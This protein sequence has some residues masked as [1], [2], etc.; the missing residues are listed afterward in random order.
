MK[1]ILSR[2]GFDE[3]AGKQASPIMPDG[4]FLSMPIPGKER[5]RT[6]YEALSYDGKTYA[7][8]I[9]ELKAKTEI[10]AGDYCHLDPDIRGSLLKRPKGWRGLFGQSNYKNSGAQGIL[11][12][13]KVK[14]GDLFLYFGWFRKTEFKASRLSYKGPD[15]HAV[16]GYLQIGKRYQTEQAL[17]D[18]AKY[19]PHAKCFTNE[20]PKNCIYEAAEKLSFNPDLPGWGCLKLNPKAKVSA[21][22]TQEGQTRSRWDPAFFKGVKMNFCSPDSFKNGYFQSAH[23]G[24]E[25]VLDVKNNTK[26]EQ[27]VSTLISDN[28]FHDRK[29]YDA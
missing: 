19:H 3:T 29:S 2:K 5:D 27:W 22:L 11:D 17:P 20:F 7:E 26:A 1:V 14:E 12:N 10:K 16:F 18:Y 4:T 8:I 13:A 23:R 15:V 6:T 21:I 28:Y 24:Q 9:K 25:F